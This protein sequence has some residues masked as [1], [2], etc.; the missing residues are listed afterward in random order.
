MKSVAGE[1]R[2]NV[3]S[4]TDEAQGSVEGVAGAGNVAQGARRVQADAEQVAAAV[5]RP[6]SSLPAVDVSGV[7]SAVEGKVQS[8]VNQVAN[9]ASTVAERAIREIETVGSPGRLPAVPSVGLLSLPLPEL[10]HAGALGQALDAVAPLFD[11]PP[12]TPL[13]SAPPPRPSELQLGAERSGP[14]SELLRGPLTD[15]GGIESSRPG[16]RLGSLI[17]PAPSAFR[18]LPAAISHAYTDSVGGAPQRAPLDGPS[19]APGGP[20]TN[21]VPGLGGG[22]FFVPLAALLALLAL[23]A[24]ATFRRP[25]EA[26]D[27]PVPSLFVCALERPG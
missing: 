2:G 17:G 13:L 22:A 16:E 27:S 26:W 11:P 24:S 1:F 4:L 10:G 12:P 5:R 14:Q 25:R 23:V 19:P 3:E 21:A 20:S 6:P 8:T 15:V 7:R 9:S 18:P